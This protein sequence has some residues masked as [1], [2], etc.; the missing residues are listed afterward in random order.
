MAEE[1]K[2]V[3]LIHSNQGE[4]F[5]DGCADIAQPVLKDGPLVS[6]AYLLF[7]KLKNRFLTNRC[8][9]SWVREVGDAELIIILDSAYDWR[10]PQTIKKKNPDAALLLL[11]WNPIG[12]KQI[13]IMRHFQ[14]YGSVATYNLDDALRFGIQFVPSFYSRDYAERF[15]SKEPDGDVLFLG[16]DKGRARQLSKFANALNSHGVPNSFIVVD[17]NVAEQEEGLI[18]RSTE[19]SYPDYCQNASKALAIFDL[20]QSGVF[21]LNLRAMEALFFQRKLITTNSRI[22]ECDFFRP[23]NILVVENEDELSDRI[24]NFLASPFE[25]YEEELLKRYEIRSVVEG[26]RQQLCD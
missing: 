9:G 10:L 8:Y 26:L 5:F 7:R 19:L 15:E 25:P 13:K 2:K 4:Y 14:G 21:A 1:T 20:S 18:Y 6:L 17:R 3:L 11:F 16:R 24:E 22:T 12:E 23:E